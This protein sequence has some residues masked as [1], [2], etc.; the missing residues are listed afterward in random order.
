MKQYLAI[1]AAALLSTAAFAQSST[2]SIFDE[3]D[4]DKNGGISQ[5]EAQAH[6]VVAQSFAQADANSDGS[7]TKEEFSAAYTASAPSQSAP[8]SQP[9]AQPQ[10]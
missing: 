9:P 2:S 6:P 10:Q 8:P 4:K 1:A 3:L 7:I 5:T